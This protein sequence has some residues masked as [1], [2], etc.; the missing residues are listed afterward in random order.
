MANPGPSVLTDDEMD[1]LTAQQPAPTPTAGAPPAR[2]TP[3]VLTDDEMDALTAARGAL[4]RPA[5]P[6]PGLLESFRRGA[7]EGATFGFEDE[8]GLA[9]RERQELSRRTNPWIHFAGEVGGGF[10]P[11]ALAALLPT[12]VGQ[13][14]AAGRL[15]QLA[16]RGSN[17]VRGL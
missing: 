7:L 3:G 1:A 10:V 17:L 5:G 9:D 15:A 11:M 8:L 2:S 4:P 14:A 6:A 13:T 12:G 16:Y